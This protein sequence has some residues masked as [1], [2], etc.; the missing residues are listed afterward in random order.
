MPYK[1]GKVHKVE[2]AEKDKL[3]LEKLAK[4]HKLSQK[5]ITGHLIGLCDKY[6]LMA[7]DWQARLLG[8]D[9]KRKDYTRLDDSCPAL[10]QVGEDWKCVWG[11]DGKT[12]EFKTL[13]E[14]FD[15]ALEVCAACKKTLNIKLE[16]ESY[17]VK[18]QELETKLKVQSTEKFKVP[19]CNYGG[20]L[21]GD[22]VSF[23]GCRLHPGK[24]LSIEN[25]CMVRINGKPCTSYIERLIGVGKKLD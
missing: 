15:E 10:I 3:V 2:L 9:K 16:N 5:E 25:F 7:G 23:E 6:N 11:R 14:D 19:V 20:I 17:Q 24:T 8:D 13:S 12:H 4:R 1:R 18:V 22:G 21:A